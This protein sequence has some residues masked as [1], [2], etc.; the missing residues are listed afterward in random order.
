MI[1]RL[2]H[3]GR[4]RSRERARELLERFDLA[5]AGDRPAKTYSGGMRRRLDLAGAPGR[6]TR[7]C[8][9]STS[10]PPASTR[11]AAP[12]CGRSSPSLV[13][14]G[15]HAAADHPVPRGGRPARRRHR[16]DRPR[17]GH[18]P[19]H[20]R[21]AQGRRSAAS[22]SR[23]SCTPARAST[24]R[25]ASCSRR[26]PSASR[27]STSSTRRITV[28]GLRRR[29]RSLVDAL[30]ALDDAG[31]DRRR[32]RA[33]PAHARRRL[34]HPH[35][36]RRRA[37]PSRRRRPR[38][39]RTGR[40]GRPPRGGAPMSALPT[41]VTDGL[42]VAKRNLIKIKR[43]PD[44]LVFATL[45]PIMFVLLFAYVFGGAIDVAG[46]RQ[47]PRVPASPG[48]FA[49]TVV[50]GAHD[51]RRRPGRGHAEGHHRPVP[52]AA[53][54]AVGGAVRPHRRRRRRQRPRRSS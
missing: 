7:R 44:L 1:G 6:A 39:G 18:R 35:R 13:A 22:G 16:R 42:V 19:G 46:R 47:L 9:S 53:D 5:D 26:S 24:T 2:Y 20:R 15:H 17:P 43:V 4:R 48:I 3:L 40:T 27:A 28:A 31:V 32:R 25:A 41:A 34:P 54:G 38:R 12:T 14:G 45:S 30:R 49:Q 8:C 11:A 51:H 33:A 37:R 50:F 29:R 21:R 23:S 52:V 36:P 10:R